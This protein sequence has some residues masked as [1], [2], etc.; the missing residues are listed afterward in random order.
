MF[1]GSGDA[2]QALVAPSDL[3]H[4]FCVLD[5][6]G[7]CFVVPPASPQ[8]KADPEIDGWLVGWLASVRRDGGSHGDGE[9]PIFASRGGPRR[10]VDQSIRRFDS[11]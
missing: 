1:G 9:F 3:K 8:E 5:A 4:F 6:H 7:R 2:S 10:S 11:F